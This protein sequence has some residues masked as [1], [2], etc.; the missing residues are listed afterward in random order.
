MNPTAALQRIQSETLA[1][2][3]KLSGSSVPDGSRRSAK[4]VFGLGTVT[5]FLAQCLTHV[6]SSTK[7]FVGATAEDF[8][9]R[10]LLRL[11]FRI[12]WRGQQSR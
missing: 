2:Q 5:Y 7:N 3:R 6:Q 10:K 11:H 1:E 12:Q 8:T 4:R 9:H